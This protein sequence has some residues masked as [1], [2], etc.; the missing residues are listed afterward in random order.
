[1]KKK[2]QTN[3]T[4]LMGSLLLVATFL[5]TVA[6]PQDPDAA[7]SRTHAKGMAVAYPWAFKKGTKT[8][9]NTA[10]KTVEELIRRA[11]YASVPGT[12]A[13]SAWSATGYQMPVV[14][15][16]PTRAAL[17]AY[18]AKTRANQILYGSI[19]WRTRSIWVNLGPKT[20]STATVNAYV[21]DVRQNKVVF[22]NRNVT[23][24]SDEKSNGYKV[25]AAILLTP[26]VTAVSGGPATP[27]EQRAVQIALGLAFRA[28]VTPYLSIR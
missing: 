4:L 6:L 10:I 24:R 14:G 25:A 17:K 11:N 8:A 12:T 19:T 18:G 3:S 20:I 21:Y 27:Q 15:R 26:I 22:R 28:W 5:P 2:L 23:G 7:I 13:A 16:M 9:R 1:V